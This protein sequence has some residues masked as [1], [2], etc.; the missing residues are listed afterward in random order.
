[1]TGESSLRWEIARG[2][3]ADLRGYTLNYTQKATCEQIIGLMSRLSDD[4]KRRTPTLVPGS[5]GQKAMVGIWRSELNMIEAR[6]NQLIRDVIRTNTSPDGLGGLQSR[7]LT[8]NGNFGHAAKIP[9]K[10]GT[11]F[12][13]PKP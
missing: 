1:M 8:T 2:L 4:M 9:P 5:T 13:G 12:P 3:N 6:I 7:D 11:R 10:S